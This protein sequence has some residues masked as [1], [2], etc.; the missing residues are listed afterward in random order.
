MDRARQ[1]YE[2]DVTGIG[3]D[4]GTDREDAGMSQGW[5]MACIQKGHDRMRHNTDTDQT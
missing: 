4:R 3:H 2:W 1:G 5:D